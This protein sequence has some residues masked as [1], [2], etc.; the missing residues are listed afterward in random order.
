[1]LSEELDKIKTELAEHDGVAFEDLPDDWK[2]LR[3]RKP[4]DK[5][6]RA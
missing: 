3:C 2:C 6:N 1:M 4:K 5:F